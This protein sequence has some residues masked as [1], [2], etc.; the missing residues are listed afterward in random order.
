MG[1]GSLPQRCRKKSLEILTKHCLSGGVVN[2]LRI[3]AFSEGFLE[4]KPREK[5]RISLSIYFMQ[6]FERHAQIFLFFSICD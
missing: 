5:R 2:Y 4:L 6:M 3:S 1:G